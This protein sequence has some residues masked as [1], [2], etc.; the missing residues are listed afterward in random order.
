M[1]II[2]NRTIV[3]DDFRTL[4]A[5]DPITDGDIIISLERFRAEHDALEKRA[6]RLGVEIPNDIFADEVL[7]ELETVDL[8]AI[9]FPIYRDGR[10]FSTARLLR[11]G[12]FTGELRATG[13]VLRDQIA[14]MERCGFDA[15][16]VAPGK[17]LEQALEGFEDF[18]VTYQD[19]ISP[20]TSPR[21]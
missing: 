19:A 4:G 17:S 15:Y 3:E 20:R 16:Q 9:D 11:R 8:I 12:G 5:E 18:S 10:G 2:R 1:P 7:G 14:F 13:N 6:G 21:S